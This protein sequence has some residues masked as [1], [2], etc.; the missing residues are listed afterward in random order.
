MLFSSSSISWCIRLSS[1]QLSARSSSSGSESMSTT[2]IVLSCSD[3]H[4]NNRLKW[5]FFRSLLNQLDV[6]NYVIK[7]TELKNVVYSPDLP[8]VLFPHHGILQ[9]QPLHVIETSLSLLLTL[10]L[11]RSTY[12]LL[13]V[14]PKPEGT[15][16]IASCCSVLTQPSDP[17]RDFESFGWT[18]AQVDCCLLSSRVFT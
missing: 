11:F 4:G 2:V 6:V 16:S 9:D 3:Q 13:S 5:K 17:P 10:S 12:S 14:A 7:H 15:S 8:A 18:Y 1:S